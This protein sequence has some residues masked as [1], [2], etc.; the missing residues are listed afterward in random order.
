LSLVLNPEVN[1]ELLFIDGQAVRA[2]VDMQAL[3]L[4]AIVTELITHHDH[5]DDERADDEI[6]NVATTP[7]LTSLKPNFRV[8]ARRQ[9]IGPLSRS[10]R[11]VCPLGRMATGR[12]PGSGTLQTGHGMPGSPH[13]QAFGRSFQGRSG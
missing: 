5:N 1:A 7:C 10:S 13:R 11:G 8:Q 12:S 6:E 2:N 3:R 4:L 9:C